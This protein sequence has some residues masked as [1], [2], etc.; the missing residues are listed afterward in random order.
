MDGSPDSYELSDDFLAD[1]LDQ[2]E[3]VSARD[4]HDLLLEGNEAHVATLLRAAA[5]LDATFL[6]RLQNAFIMGAEGS[7]VGRAGGGGV[8]ASLALRHTSHSSFRPARLPPLPTA[9]PHLTPGPNLSQLPTPRPSTGNALTLIEKGDSEGLLAILADRPQL[10]H[11]RNIDGAC[12]LHRVVALDRAGVLG[13]VLQW[14]KT[15]GVHIN[16]DCLDLKHNT[17]LHLA[18]GAGNIAIARV[19]SGR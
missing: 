12:L 18:A 14:Q 4:F 2:A 19:R 13:A 17:P 3:G 11:S 16:V 10:I 8:V 1:V 6:T 9:A 15:A 7:G 5:Q